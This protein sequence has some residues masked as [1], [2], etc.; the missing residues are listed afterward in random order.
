MSREFSVLICAGDDEAK[1]YVGPEG[2]F[3]AHVRAHRA[4][5]SSTPR[6]PRLNGIVDRDEVAQADPDRLQS[7]RA[8]ISCEGPA[9]S[10]ARN[11]NASS[12][13]ATRLPN[14]PIKHSA[15][16]VDRPVGRWQSY[17]AG[18][19]ALEARLLVNHPDLDWLDGMRAFKAE[20][21]AVIARHRAERRK[22][23]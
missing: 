19:D 1:R 8:F 18:L 23:G 3:P 16:H 6:F 17:R 10:G 22:P 15:R 4:Q 21:D 13:A 7:A 5:S 14:H 9:P 2:A 20:A 12:K 11:I